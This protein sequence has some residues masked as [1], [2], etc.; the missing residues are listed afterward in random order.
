VLTSVTLYLGVATS[1]VALRETLFQLRGMQSNLKRYAHC[2]S[3]GNGRGRGCAAVLRT[4]AS[5]NVTELVEE[6]GRIIAELNTLTKPG[7]DFANFEPALVIACIEP[8][9]VFIL[10]Q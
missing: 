2:R 4:T 8:V 3:T 5:D 10:N 1:R 7:I 6:P 9:S